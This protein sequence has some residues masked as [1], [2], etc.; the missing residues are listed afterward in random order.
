M[1]IRALMGWG[2]VDK[3]LIPGERREYFTTDKDVWNLVRQVAK[4][5][6]K[7]E[8]EPIMD[9]LEDV[10]NVEGSGAEVEEFRKVTAELERFANQAN[11]VLNLVIDSK[12]SWIG[13]V[14]GM[15]KR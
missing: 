15:F 11:T 2:L 12:K 5:R 4:E 6:K 14:I 9:V 10:K 3:K 7:R 13:R 1:N 8:L